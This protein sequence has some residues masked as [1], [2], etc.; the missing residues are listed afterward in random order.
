[1]EQNCTQVAQLEVCTL[2]FLDA[3]S[4]VTLLDRFITF[5]WYRESLRWQICAFAHRR[6]PVLAVS[7]MAVLAGITSVR[8]RITGRFGGMSIIRWRWLVVIVRVRAGMIRV[9]WRMWIPRRRR[10]VRVLWRMAVL[11]RWVWSWVRRRMVGA[12][13]GR[14]IGRVWLIY[15]ITILR[16]LVGVLGRIWRSSIVPTAGWIIVC[17][18]VWV[19]RWIVRTVGRLVRV[20]LRFVRA[21]WR[22]R[23][24]LYFTQKHVKWQ[25]ARRITA[26]SQ[27][28][29][30]YAPAV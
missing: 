4:N 10:F 16:R 9:S 13:A 20:C 21:V 2:G 22:H 1:M 15:D 3:K 6:R 24:F 30:F 7:L 5:W 18:R 17:R 29:Y 14:R 12:A 8:C 23:P 25:H 11:L 26:R 27:Y 19:T 28:G